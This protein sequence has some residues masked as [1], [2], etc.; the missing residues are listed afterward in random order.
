[1][2]KFS[3]HYC[4]YCA[5]IKYYTRGKKKKKSTGYDRLSPKHIA[6]SNPRQQR[7][8]QDS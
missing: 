4:L 5:T 6:I 8:L 7:E 3:N 1:M 2:K